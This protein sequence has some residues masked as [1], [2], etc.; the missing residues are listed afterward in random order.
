[1]H[2]FCRS[3]FKLDPNSKVCLLLRCAA[4]F[5]LGLYETAL[6][7]LENALDQF[8]D[9]AEFMENKAVC[10]ERLCRVDEAIS[11]YEKLIE[12]QPE[13]IEAKYRKPIA[14]F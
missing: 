13:A 12:K 9:D 14:I 10:L 7:Q 5:H 1:M 3:L 4:Y 8:P 6:K 2:L 11:V